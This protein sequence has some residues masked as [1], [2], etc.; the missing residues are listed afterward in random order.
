MPSLL[1]EF[2][3]RRESG[4]S[5]GRSL[6]NA[7]FQAQ[8]NLLGID[9]EEREGGFKLW[10]VHMR[11]R[12]DD[13]PVDWWFASMAIPILA[14]TLGPLANVLSIGALVTFW[15]LDLRDPTDPNN[16]VAQLVATPIRDPR[17]CYWI[18][19]CSLIT[20]FAG[21]FFLLLNFTNRIRY[22]ISLPMTIMLWIISC[23]ILIGDLAAMHVY[24]RPVAPFETYSGGFWFAISAASFYFLLASILIINLLGYIRGHYPQYFDL[25]EDQRTLIIQTMF[26]FIWLAGGA[27]IYARLEGWQFIDSLYYCN[28]TI[29]TIGFGDLYPTRTVTRALLIPFSLG[30]I[31]M[32]GLVVSSIYRSVQE[33][34][35]KK[36]TRSHFEHQRQLTEGRTVATSFELQRREVEEEMARE[37]AMA[38]QAA[39]PSSRSPAT[40]L[41]YQATMNSVTSTDRTLTRTNTLG[42]TSTIGSRMK[43][44]NKFKLLRDGKERFEE[45]RKVQ[46]KAKLWKNSWRLSMSLSLF[47]IFWCVG[48]VAF[49]QAEKGTTGQNYWETVYFC[50]VAIISIG[51]GDFSPKTGAGRCFFLIWSIIAVPSITMLASDLTSTVVS[52]FNTWSSTLADFTILPKEGIWTALVEKHP[53]LSLGL[54][55]ATREWQSKHNELRNRVEILEGMLKEKEN[56]ETE[57]SAGGSKLKSEPA[58]SLPSPVDQNRPDASALVRQLALAIRHTAHDCTL[59]KSRRYRYEDWTEF[60][61][62]IRFS[63]AKGD[64]GG[65]ENEEDEGLVHWDWLGEDSPMMGEQTESEFVLDRLCESLVR[66]LK[67]NPPDEGFVRSVRSIGEE[68]LRLRTQGMEEDAKA[69]IQEKVKAPMK[70]LVEEDHE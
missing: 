68:G 58:E 62:L 31:I 59:D 57:S 47:T 25:T 36:V 35:E 34:G 64:S 54:A 69:D 70:P 10:K 8:S 23:G 46:Q 55:K 40:A 67:R 28:V 32:L 24:N 6:K 17:W 26:Y 52:A 5:L 2:T 66:Y 33:L 63:L 50:W 61:R 13:D 48:A 49:W 30:G 41:Q 43:K 29:L 45:M 37:R 56:S 27:G 4:Q 7:M 65:M 42:K 60:T 53:W 44:E 38:K 1:D 20:G 39:R 3:S 11:G 15:R 51:Y 14:A 16:T 21:N 19:V 9:D 12:S 18:N 22:I